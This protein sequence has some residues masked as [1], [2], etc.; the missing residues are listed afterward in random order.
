MRPLRATW[1]R[2]RNLF[3]KHRLDRELD[4]ELA[5]HIEMHIADVVRKGISFSEARRNAVLRLG[6]VEQTKESHRDVRGFPFLESVARD[7]RFGVRTLAKNPGSTAVAVLTLALGIGATAAIFGLVNGILLVSL[8]YAHPEQLVSV[9][10]TYPKG[11]VVAMRQQVR[12]ADVA[13]YHEG[14]EFN[15]TGQGEPVRVAGTLV[16]AELFSILGARAEVGR[17]FVT[18]EDTAGQDRYVVISH[19]LW[20]Q[21]FGSDRSIIGRYIELEGVNRQVVGVMPADFRFPSERTQVWLPLHN[22]PRNA[23]LY[24]ADD[25]MPVLGRLHPGANIE[26]ARAEVRTFQSRV[27]ELFPWPMPASWNADVSV[28]P[29][30]EG[31]V[32]DVRTRLLVL[33]AAVLFVVLIACANVANLTLARAATREK[34]VSVRAALGAVPRRIARQVLTESVLVATLGAAMG[35]LFAMQGLALLKAWLPAETPRLAEAQV[36]WRVLLFT[37]TLTVLTGLASG[38]APALQSLKT[39]ATQALRAGGR[40]GSLPLSKHLRGALVIGEVASAVLL[41]IAAGLFIR[42]LWSLSHVNP[43]FD[44]DKLLTARL[45]PNQSYCADPD[46]CVTFYRSLLQQLQAMP[47]VSSVAVV[48]TLPLSGR[49][50]KR[51]FDLEGYVPPLGQNSPL[52]W[53]H[54]VSPD[55]FRVMRIPVVL[56]R[57]FAESDQAGAPV[58]IVTAA[59]ARRFWPNQ[60]V[61]GK[62]IRLLGESDWRTIVGIVSDVRCYDLQ[63]DIPSWMAGAAYLP[64]NSAA[65]LEDKRLPAEMTLVLRSASDDAQIAKSLRATVASLNPEMPVSEVKTMAAVVSDAAATSRST[66]F[67]FSI[68][69]ALALTLGTIGIYGVLSFLV[70]NRTREIGIRMAIGAQRRDVLWSILREGGK[71]S[72]SGIALG[73]VGAL[74]LTRAL[75]SQLY[76]ISVTDP[77]T[78]ATVPLIIAIVALLAC[79]VPAR[80]ATRVDP[81]TA[82]RYE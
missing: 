26:Q 15:L 14:A 67:L 36:D 66:T 9:T 44:A 40:D 81:M 78:F 79:Y 70:S 75:T 58:A 46:R 30:Q 51:T 68:F 19:A 55:Y 7:L 65:T 5:A 60:N 49:V 48:N 47:A 10:A 76:G 50:A 28:V 73:A 27:G 61:V 16:S 32:T 62:H 24:W 41:V 25:F 82:L 1:V 63:Q 57:D 52:F 13:A 3:R 8:P 33:L 18:G 53:L 12:S 72:L 69:A 23:V 29:L 22:D 6:G 77:V 39:S 56:G 20:Q 2:F 35:I 80:R 45:T 34:E 43:G 21:R 4:D 59:T 42:S 31:M 38:L 74:L 64:Y 17:T 11:A 71:L 37:A 54:A